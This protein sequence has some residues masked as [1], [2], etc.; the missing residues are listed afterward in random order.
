MDT[1]IT[2]SKYLDIAGPLF[3]LLLSINLL[4]GKKK[5]GCYF[6]IIGY[7]A[8]QLTTNSIAKY[9]MRH[10]IPNI[11]IYQANAFFSLL[12]ISWWF[13]QEL[14]KRITQRQ[15]IWL[16][17]YMLC[18]VCLIVPILIH[19]HERTL[20]SL[21]LSF[22]SFSVCL[23]CTI[24]YVTSLAKPD[25]SNL[26]GSASFWIVTAFFLYYST[27]FFIYVSF[28]IFSKG[29]STDFMI[30]WNIHNLLLFISCCILGFSCKK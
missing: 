8:M 15:F 25:E 13:L 9:M 16:R 4:F 3:G 17:W 27:C 28:K 22:T 12:I 11:K 7:L 29:G 1:L 18:A 20:N 6:I 30:L 23:Y 24:F 14:K 21:S 10:E 5:A 2:I 19:E 26:L